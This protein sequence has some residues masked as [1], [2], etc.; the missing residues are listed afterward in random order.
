MNDIG[1]KY[2]EE[3]SVAYLKLLAASNEV[4]MVRHH[5][6]DNDGVDCSL[7]INFGDKLHNVS[8]YVQLKS[9]SNIRFNG[10]EFFYD[11]KAKNYND[12]CSPSHNPRVVFILQLPENVKYVQ[13]NEKYNNLLVRYKMFWYEIKKGTQSTNNQNYIRIKIPKGNYL[14]E[15]NFLKV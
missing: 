10:N 15:E 14:T 3:I 7:H 5:E 2:K 12:L 6:N 4:K 1:T 11:L 8:I 13:S 9:S